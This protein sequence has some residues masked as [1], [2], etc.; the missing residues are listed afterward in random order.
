MAPFGRLV[1]YVPTSASTYSFYALPTLPPHPDLHT[2]TPQGGGKRKGSFAI[3]LEPWHAD[4]FDFLDLKKN[5]GK[6]EM[7]ARDLFYGGWW[8][9]CV[10]A[11]RLTDENCLRGCP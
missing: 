3:Y 11:V 4:V 10:M 5:S 7:R 2:Q 1:V 8:A 6:E 9:C